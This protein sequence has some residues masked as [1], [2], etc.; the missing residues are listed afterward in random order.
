MKRTAI[1]FIIS[2]YAFTNIAQQGSSAQ[3]SNEIRL[4]V[5]SG[6]SIPIAFGSGICC[7]VA[8]SQFYFSNLFVS[9]W[10]AQ[11]AM[12]LLEAIENCDKEGLNPEDYHFS[13]LNTLFTKQDKT[14]LEQAEFE[15][16]LT[17]SF[18]L[19]AS[20]MMSGKVDPT[21]IDSNWK[22]VRREGDPV[23]LLKLAIGSSDIMGTLYSI[24]PKYKA[25]ARLMDKL[26]LHLQIAEKG[27]WEKIADGETIRIGAEDNR[28]VAIRK[29]LRSTGDLKSEMDEESKIYDEDV[30]NAIKRFQKRHGL[31]IDGNVGKLTLESLNVPVEDRIKDIRVN[32]ERCRWL[33]QDL[34]D[35]YIMV[36]IPAF[37][38]EV[39]K[40]GEVKIEMDVAVGKP[41]RETPVFSSKM[42]YLV[43]NPYW[44]VP[45]TILA[46][47]MIPAQAKNPNYLKNVNIK[48][49]DTRG[50]V[51][52]PATIDW[53]TVS[54]KTFPYILRQDPGP[55]NALGEVKFIFP[56]PYN[57]YMHDT[58]HRELFVKADRALSSGCIRLSRPRQLE[59][60]LLI[61]NSDW[62]EEKISEVLKSQQNYTVPLAEPLMVY[63]QY[64]T[65]FIDEQGLHNFRK[66]VYGRNERVYRALTAIQ[67]I[68]N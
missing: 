42:I 29:R 5:E 39:I 16:L 12:G 54:A 32:L 1:T 23:E 46:N 35:H 41:Y 9:I 58:N 65:S 53:N 44:T 21:L 24:R 33:P 63:L 59:E 37:E 68:L 7:R 40:N 22:T 14:V 36:N 15:L 8:V 4:K 48:V 55:N 57:V 66:D 61:E 67:P 47:D 43:L 62:T 11:R 18:L 50:N 49:L 38:M 3:L 30:Q 28:V 52:D 56:N 45:P 19:L 60:Y 20:H 26:A 31:E 51:V 13:V 10:N 34:G 6:S 64:W 17:D 25:Y 2:L 27:G